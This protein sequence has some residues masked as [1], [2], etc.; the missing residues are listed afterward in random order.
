M[1]SS[2]PRAPRSTFPATGHAPTSLTKPAEDEA[3]A[4]MALDLVKEKE[5]HP[6]RA[7]PLEIMP[8]RFSSSQASKDVE[9]KTLDRTTVMMTSRSTEGIRDQALG[10]YGGQP[11]LMEE[12]RRCNRGNGRGSVCRAIAH[13]GYVLCLRHVEARRNSYNKLQLKRKQQASEAA[14]DLKDK[15]TAA[16]PPNHLSSQIVLLPSGFKC[17]KFYLDTHVPTQ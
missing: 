1:D 3:A 11:L 5:H 6:V 4:H 12:V 2:S 8:F 17:R 14:G 16:G 15:H 7:E 10:E 9:E 13:P